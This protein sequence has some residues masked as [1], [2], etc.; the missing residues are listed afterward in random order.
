MR[1]SVASLKSRGT[2]SNI[3]TLLHPRL[4]AMIGSILGAAVTNFPLVKVNAF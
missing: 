4:S 1:Q 3:Q 2:L